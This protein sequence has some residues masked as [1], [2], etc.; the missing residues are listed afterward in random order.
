[1]N[2]QSPVHTRSIP[3]WIW[4]FLRL[5]GIPFVIYVIW[6]IDW[7]EVLSI[8]QRLGL[9]TMLGM[10]AGLLVSFWIKVHRWRVLLR[11][12]GIEPTWWDVFFAFSEAYFYGFLTPARLGEA[13]R[14]R[15]LSQWGLGMK[16]AVGNLLVERGMDIAFLANLGLFTLGFYSTYPSYFGVAYGLVAVVVAS[17]IGGWI[18]WRFQYL[19]TWIAHEDGSFGN[20]RLV[21]L[22][23]GHTVASWAILYLIVFWVRGVL[24][25]P[26][27][28]AMTLFCF[29]LST[30]V[31]AI[32]VSVA[33][34]GTK[35]LALMQFLAFW[36]YPPEQAVA[37]SLIFALVFVLN[38]LFSGAI[39]FGILARRT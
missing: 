36:G 22:C 16:R 7:S 27:G 3:P 28:P 20:W 17:G 12:Q 15:H 23:C 8:Y 4:R 37:F 30:A 31:T 24:G 38:L 35:E 6:K 13:Y 21:W 18:L 33:G 2:T 5:A 11:F 1:M 10:L 25:I 14:M 39:W 34:L 26:M 19:R 9:L 29:V 32:P